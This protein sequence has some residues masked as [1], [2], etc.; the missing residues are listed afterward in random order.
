M[1]K[2]GIAWNTLDAWCRETIEKYAAQGKVFPEEVFGIFR[3]HD[4][5]IKNK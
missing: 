2:Q 1:E 5:K 3:Y 4:V